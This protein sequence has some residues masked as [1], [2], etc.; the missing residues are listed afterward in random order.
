[1]NA[2]GMLRLAVPHPSSIHKEILEDSALRVI[3][4]S[5]VTQSGESDYKVNAFC[6]S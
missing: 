3:S 4:A 1:M 5:E 2:V 6:G